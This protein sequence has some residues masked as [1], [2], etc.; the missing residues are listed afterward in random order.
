MSAVTWTSVRTSLQL[1]L[2]HNASVIDRSPSIVF[3][4]LHRAI[5]PWAS[6]TRSRSSL[7]SVASTR[8]SSLV[9]WSSASPFQQS[10]VLDDFITLIIRVNGRQAILYGRGALAAPEVGLLC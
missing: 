6:R 7:I 10:P 9:S 2:A 1:F 8:L 3:T 5:P 4:F